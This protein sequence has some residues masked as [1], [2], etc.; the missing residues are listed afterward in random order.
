MNE[1]AAPIIKLKSGSVYEDKRNYSRAVVCDNWI[2]VSNTAG[3]NYTTRE[4]SDCAG[5]QTEQCFRNIEGALEAVG[6]TL[7][8]VVRIRVSIPHLEFKEEVMDV[9]AAKFEGIDPA[10]TVTA[11]PLAGPDYKVEIEATAYRG[12]GDRVNT[13]VRKQL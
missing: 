4:M 10:S 5:E 11:T 9:V 6:A 3:R 12:A 7:A 2:L 8:D 13:Y 1:Q